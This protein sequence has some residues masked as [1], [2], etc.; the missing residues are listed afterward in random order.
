MAYSGPIWSAR[1]LA[2]A[3]QAVRW[4]ATVVA[5]TLCSGAL[6]RETVGSST[7]GCALVRDSG[8]SDILQRRTGP[9]PGWQRY[10]GLR[11]VRDGL[12]AVNRHLALVRDRVGSADLDWALVR[13]RVGSAD[14]D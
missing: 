8:G 1:L 11:A 2:V 14:L 3:P 7:S 12:A 10:I 6:V 9:R 5:M 4:S 13:D